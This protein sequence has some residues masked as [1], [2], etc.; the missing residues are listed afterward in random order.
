MSATRPA[1]E[2]LTLRGSAELEEGLRLLL[3]EATRR[4][5]QVVPRQHVRSLA[6]VGGYGRGEGGV[7]VEDGNERPHNNLDLLLATDRLAPAQRAE[8]KGRLDEALRPLARR[9]RVGIDLSVVDAG[10]IARDDCRVMWYDA[11]HGHRTLLGDRDFWPGLSR[12]SVDRIV[13]ED[14]LDLLVNRGTLLLINDLLLARHGAA[15]RD[16]VL[17]HAA[18]AVIGYGDALLFFRGDYH[19]SYAER[20]ERMARRDDV[21]PAFQALYQQAMEFRFAPSEAPFGRADLQRFGRELRAALARVHLQVERLR[22]R[23]PDLGWAGYPARAL[24]A[25]LGERPLSARAWARRGRNLLWGEHRDLPAPLL[26]RLGFRALGPGAAL[27]A[28][29][30]VLAYGAAHPGDLALAG[31]AL[32]TTGSHPL[33]LARAYLRAWGTW[34]D[35]N[36]AP[37]LERMGLSLDVRTWA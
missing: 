16:S 26:A 37:A 21:E 18:K 8:L 31:A 11:R 24:T 4:V 36:L 33:G 10:G 5:A 28:V 20:R 7:L 19:W 15:A 9:M 2:R 1:T 32:G 29:F 34:R 14:A 30:P 25:S 23:V 13:P 35:P 22:L 12:F 27:R 17:R 6:L 3:R